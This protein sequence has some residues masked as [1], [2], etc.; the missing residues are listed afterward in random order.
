MSLLIIQPWFG[1]VGHP[2]QSLINMASAIGK[3]ERV[4]Y[5]VS[6]NSDSELCLNSMQRLKSWGKVHG[7]SVK[8]FVGR[9]NTLRA[10]WALCRLWIKGS[11][12][13]RIFFFDSS[14]PMLALL[15]PI[16]ARVCSVERISFLHLHGPELFDRSSWLSRLVTRR[17]LMRPEV[18]FYLRTEE[19]AQAWTVAYK[20]IAVG[21]RISTL[22]SLEIPDGAV[23][24]HPL[25]PTAQVKFGLVGQ[26]RPGKGLDWL[27]PAFQK[28]PDIGKLTVAGEYSSHESHAQLSFLDE[29]DGFVHCFMSEDEMLQRSAMQDYLLMLYDGSWDKRMES[30]VLYLAAR[31][32]RPVVVYGD[33]WSGRMVREFGCGIEAPV[34]RQQRIEFLRSIPRP[35]SIEYAGLL[36]GM[37][38]FREAHSVESLRPVLMQELLG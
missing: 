5:L 34:D 14:L 38:A 33:S 1:A 19:L 3:D 10:F 7:F 4:E 12:Y 11:R 24:Q 21:N 27:V 6:M 35:G 29:F 30:A 20:D 2:A 17:F 25:Q 9:D 37:T 36:D 13:Q 15:W 16:F 26:I 28:Y 23:H 22:P 32:N 31:V 8:T 18:R